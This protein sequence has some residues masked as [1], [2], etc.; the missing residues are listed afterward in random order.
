MAVG[1]G[2][3]GLAIAAWEHF[4]QQKS[5][6]SPVPSGPPSPPPPGPAGA[7]TAPPVFQPGAGP[8]P[9]PPP[10]QADAPRRENETPEQRA[11]REAALLVRG[12]AAAAWADGSVDVDERAAIADRLA[13]SGLPEEDR[14]F[15]L[16]DLEMPPR[17]DDILSQ[18]DTPQLAEQ[19]YLVSLLATRADT[20][21]ERTYLRN[22][23]ARTGLDTAATRRLHLLVGISI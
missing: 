20:P 11:N 22:L 12:M 17:L 1:M 6:A 10:P 4:S 19:L 23:A 5:A 3:V 18:V 15:F 2:A 8:P 9:F 7:A 16:R 21:A 13:T 14:A